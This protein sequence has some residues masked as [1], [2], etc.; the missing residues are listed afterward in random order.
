MHRVWPDIR[1]ERKGRRVCQ[2]P[3]G[4]SAC[5]ARP[6]IPSP[7]RHLPRPGS[8]RGR[9]TPMRADHIFGPDDGGLHRLLV[10][11]QGR[12]SIQTRRYAQ[13]DQRRCH[14]L[15]PG[16]G[17]SVGPRLC[18]AAPR[19]RARWGCVRSGAA[20]WGHH[21]WHA[22]ITVRLTA[23]SLP[24]A[25]PIRSLRLLPS[26]H[27]RTPSAH[28]VPKPHP[29]LTQ[30][31]PSF[32]PLPSL[33]ASQEHAGGDRP[34]PPPRPHR[35]RRRSPAFGE[36]H[37]SC[38]WASAARR[39][40]PRRGH[41]VVRGERDAAR[42]ERRTMPDSAN[43]GRCRAA[44]FEGVLRGGGQFGG[45]NGGRHGEGLSEAL[46]PRLRAHRRSGL[47][48]AGS[49]P[50]VPSLGRLTQ[51]GSRARAPHSHGRESYAST[52]RW[53]PRHLRP[54]GLPHYHGGLPAGLP[55]GS[56]ELRR[57]P[58]GPGQPRQRRC[59]LRPRL[60]GHDRP[61]QYA[62]ARAPALDVALHH[63]RSPCQ[64]VAQSIQEH[65]GADACCV[66]VRLLSFYPMRHHK[67]C[68]SWD[69]SSGPLLH[70]AVA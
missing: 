24:H 47:P 5:A 31:S 23:S 54:P 18:V 6:G 62:H 25:E 11:R 22:P 65:A 36:L 68:A 30:A 13:R 41:A 38:T 37:T 33:C 16:C 59:V 1:T 20:A 57:R 42:R 14:C 64:L 50:T 44:L 21:V 15:S 48:T 51:P 63:E 32:V 26:S 28:L 12:R 35:Y 9:P 40:P 17:C 27:P 61:R 7:R 46:S 69:Q 8:R 39:R 53:R 52:G 2:V 4:G 10:L 45:P 49:A 66:P 58:P 70:H 29:S 67:Y 55:P 34:R 56:R 60:L 43:S 19:S 3:L